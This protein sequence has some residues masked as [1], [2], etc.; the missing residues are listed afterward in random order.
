LTHSLFD[1]SAGGVIGGGLGGEGGSFF[2]SFKTTRSRRCPRDH[3][4]FGIGDRDNGVV[5]GRLN[6]SDSGRNI[7]LLFFW[8]G[9][10]GWSRHSF[11]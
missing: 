6:V 11:S 5:E 1:L 7:F 10:F 9:F 2:S 4:A 3:I 8:S